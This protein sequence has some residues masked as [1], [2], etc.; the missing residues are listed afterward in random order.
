MQGGELM[1]QYQ[2]DKIRNVAFL[3]HGGCGKTSLVESILFHNKDIDRLGKVEEGNTVSDYDAEEIRRQISIGTSIIPTEWKG[4]KINIIDTPGYFDFVGEVISG[5]KIADSAVIVVDATAGV[6]VGTEKAWSYAENKGIPSLI[7]VNKLD[8]ENSAFF[9][10]LEQLREIFGNKVAPFQVPIGFESNFKGLVN[11]AEMKATQTDGKTIKEIPIPDN[12]LDRVGPLREMLIESVAE[13]DDDLLEKFFA[14]DEFTDLEI[15]DGLRKGVIEGKIVPILC[16]SA[17]LGTG[18]P[19]FLDNILNFFPSIKDLEM[20]EGVNP[21]NQQR[22]TRLPEE[23]EAFSAYVFKTIAD[24]YVGKLSMLKVISGVLTSNGSIYNSTCEKQEKIGQVYIIKGKKQIPVDKVVPGDI[25]AVAKLQYTTTGDTLCDQN[26]PIVYDKIPFPHPVIS[27]AA[28]PKSKG[29]EDKI[30]G[31]LQ[32]LME[33]DPTFMVE[34]NA[35]TLQTLIS[36]Q[37]EL[38]IEII[39]NKLKAKFGVDVVLENPRVPYRETIKSKAKVEGKHK[40]QSGGHGQYGHVWIEFEPCTDTDFTFEEKIFGGSVPKQY[41]PAVEKGLRECI[42]TGVL[43]G[44]PVVNLRATLLDGSY[45]DVD[46]SE[47]A[48]KVAASL[49]YKK[50]LEQAKPILLEPISRVE[51]LIPD[52]YMGDIM[53]DLNKR[54]GRILGMEQRDGMQ[55]VIAE[56]PQSEMFKYATDLR[57]MTQAKGNFSM[58]FERYDEVPSQMTTKIIEDAKALKEK[59]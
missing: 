23:D 15:K 22:E 36:A 38:H 35:E 18:M 33:E 30:N 58:K 9:K 1:K 11:I 13:S 25:A 24:P 39:I 37:G 44:Y 46:S 4:H 2:T 48:F 19:E 31:G 14:G 27:M 54:R 55:L 42:G 3:G 40:K 16:T 26:K 12:L 57:S 5:L 10:V 28:A 59:E 43:A 45:H 29:D 20:E 7:V 56:V 32:R 51:V 17:S 34:K 50:G 41:V 8:R 53:G 49:A 47:M 21:K 52:E 6:Q